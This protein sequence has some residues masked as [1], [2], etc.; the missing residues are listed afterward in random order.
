M[1]QKPDMP[2]VSHEEVLE[3]GKEKGEVMGRLVMRIVERIRLQEEVEGQ[4]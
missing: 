4:K 2:E 3:L 1:V